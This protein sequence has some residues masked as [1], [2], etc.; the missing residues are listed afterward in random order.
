MRHP[1]FLQI[2]DLS[3]D[4]P[5]T[6]VYATLVALQSSDLLHVRDGAL[7]VYRA[8]GWFEFFASYLGTH[9]ITSLLG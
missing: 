3:R 5:I 6:E 9:S 2:S 8:D 7:T 1:R 4:E